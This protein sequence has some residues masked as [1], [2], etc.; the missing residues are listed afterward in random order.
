MA[1]LVIVSVVALSLL[2]GFILGY[3]SG[4]RNRKAIRDLLKDLQQ[5]TWRIGP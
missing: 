2:V 4:W 3:I 1:D 5:P